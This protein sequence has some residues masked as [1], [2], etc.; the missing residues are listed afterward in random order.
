MKPRAFSSSAHQ[1]G[2]F[3]TQKSSASERPALPSIG[4]GQLCH[5]FQS[6]LAKEGFVGLR[7]PAKEHFGGLFL[8]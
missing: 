2:P 4:D 7:L 1:N 5:W 3:P 8:T 6:N